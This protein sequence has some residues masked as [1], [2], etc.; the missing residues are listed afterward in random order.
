MTA[1]GKAGE[2]EGGRP[3]GEGGRENRKK[4]TKSFCLA[5]RA[6]HFRLFFSF[7]SGKQNPRIFFSLRIQPVRSIT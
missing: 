5:L 3:P 7:F 2:E 6:R 4:L 1:G